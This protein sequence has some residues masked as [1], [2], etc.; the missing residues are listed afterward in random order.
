MTSVFQAIKS[1]EEACKVLSRSLREKLLRTRWDEHR[2]SPT[3]LGW[4]IDPEITCWRRVKPRILQTPILH[5]MDPLS[6]SA[7]QHSVEC[8]SW[9]YPSS[10]VPRMGRC[11]PC[12]ISWEY[13][14]QC[15]NSPSPSQY[16]GNLNG[17]AGAKSNLGPH[18]YLGRH[19]GFCCNASWR[20]IKASD[21]V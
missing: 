6:H 7:R 8:V 19:L 20:R 14:P 2:K 4:L 21:R 17:T 3:E 1:D 9:W 16:Q 13:V 15:D 5:I 10:N 18:R 12:P 11:Y